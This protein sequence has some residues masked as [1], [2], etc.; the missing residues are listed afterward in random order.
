MLVPWLG[1]ETRAR[2]GAAARGA[3]AGGGGAGA[4]RLR[5]LRRHD[6][7]VHRGA[8]RQAV[9]G[10]LAASARHLLL[11]RLA[12]AYPP[13]YPPTPPTLSLID[14]SKRAFHTKRY[15]RLGVYYATAR[16]EV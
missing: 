14:P 11:P 4:R 9:P 13:P 6:Q 5:A 7:E 8:H 1:T 2:A 16:S 12:A 15:N 10:A 3:G